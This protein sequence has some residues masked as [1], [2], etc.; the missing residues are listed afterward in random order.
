M[1]YRIIR[2]EINK[3]LDR[4]EIELEIVHEGRATPKRV[5]VF[6]E[7]VEKFSL[8]PDK[9]ILMYLKTMRGTN[10]SIALIYYYPNGI[11]WSTI[12]PIKR[13]KV[14]KLGEGEG[15]EEG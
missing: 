10:K 11:D 15:K 4:R 1:E 14:I 9:T 5:I 2:D 12:E 13:K 7:I 8:D 3:F 6:K